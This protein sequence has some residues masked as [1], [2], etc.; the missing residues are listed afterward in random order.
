MRSD[1]AREILRDVIK[2]IKKET[3]D[4][5]KKYFGS[6]GVCTRVIEGHSGKKY[7]VEIQA[8]WDH[9]PGMN[10]R[11]FISIDDGGWQR[12]ICPITD[13]FIIAPDGSFIGE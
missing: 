4:E 3:Y 1:E 6:K 9:K 5:I 13:D 11:V 10:I 8:F 2:D 7:N 12:I